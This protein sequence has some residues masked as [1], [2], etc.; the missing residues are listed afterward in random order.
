VKENFDRESRL[1]KFDEIDVND[2]QPK[3]FRRKR[4][5]EAREVLIL[6]CDFWTKTRLHFL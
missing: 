4:K 1:E 6:F 5:V 3:R 2:R